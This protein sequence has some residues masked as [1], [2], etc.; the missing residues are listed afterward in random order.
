MSLFYTPC[1]HCGWS[2]VRQLAIPAPSMPVV[3]SVGYRNVTL[4]WHCPLEG[5]AHRHGGATSSSSSSSTTGEAPA[6]TGYALVWHGQSFGPEVAQGPGVAT[7]TR[8]LQQLLGSESLV[9]HQH[10]HSHVDTDSEDMDM[11]AHR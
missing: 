6:V 4:M 7:T 3:R 9:G 5:G 2:Q 1:L 10:R 8:D 11:A